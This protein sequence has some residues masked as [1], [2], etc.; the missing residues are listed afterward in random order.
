MSV[1]GRSPEIG[2]YESPYTYTPEYT[3]VIH[4]PFTPRVRSPPCTPHCPCPTTSQL[5]EL[6]SSP[7]S[8]GTL[9]R[10]PPLTN[11]RR[12][13][14][15]V[16][17]TASAP[18]VLVGPTCG[19]SGRRRRR[20]TPCAAGLAGSC[21]PRAVPPRPLAPS[22]AATADLQPLPAEADPASERAAASRPRDRRAAHRRRRRGSPR[23][24][25]P[26][27]P[28]GRRCRT[29]RRWSRRRTAPR[30]SVTRQTHKRQVSHAIERGLRT[31]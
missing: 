15:S 8:P 20:P 29:A 9:A 27:R 14:A 18:P 13:P 21:G 23:R 17:P 22:A 30:W 6:A 19:R 7:R 31:R 28:S 24:R 10:P 5:I 25:R 16:G 11:G 2:V 3:R 4:T 26:P 1:R 12:R